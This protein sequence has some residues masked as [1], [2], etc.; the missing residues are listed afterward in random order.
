MASAGDFKLTPRQE[1]VLGLLLT[2]PTIHQAA[3]AAKIGVRTVFRWLKDEAFVG[4]YREARAEVVGQAVG[5]V[6][7]A[8]GSA[9]KTLI[10]IMEDKGAPA[11]SRVQAARTMIETAIKT[12]ELEEIETR[13]SSLEKQLQDWNQ[14]KGKGR[15]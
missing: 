6:Q 4:A 8:M 10:G 9:V 15:L 13:L 2:E 3:E 11:S 14:T 7:A 5:R 12:V 1:K